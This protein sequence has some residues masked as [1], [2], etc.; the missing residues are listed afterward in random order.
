MVVRKI[1]SQRPLWRSIVEESRG[2]MVLIAGGVA[3]LGA[4]EEGEQSITIVKRLRKTK[5]MG[6]SFMQLHLFEKNFSQL[7]G[8]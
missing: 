3:W 8:L 1:A 7:L 2:G 5:G 4:H 6:R